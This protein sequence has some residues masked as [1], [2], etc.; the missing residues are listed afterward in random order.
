MS[1]L[2]LYV[3]IDPEL[4]SEL[5]TP[6]VAFGEFTSN[7]PGVVIYNSGGEALQL[8]AFYVD[9]ICGR[10]L[11]LQFVTRELKGIASLVAIALFMDRA[12]AL[13]PKVPALI[14]A[15]ELVSALQEGG[16]A[17]IDR[18]LARLLLFLD[19][20]FFRTPLTKKDM[21]HK[22][23]QVVDWI[24]VWVL[25]GKIPSMGKEPPPPKVL[26]RGTNG[27]VVAET[28]A[29]SQMV[30]G[31]V[32]LY[33]MGFLRG[34]LYAVGA[35]E[36]TYVLAFRKSKYLQF[37]LQEAAGR[38]NGLEAARGNPEGWKVQRHFLTS[39]EWGTMTPRDTLTGVFLRI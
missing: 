38:L 35:D 7:H 8:A 18:D 11:P 22:L 4:P 25:E 23:A 15:V 32:E 6:A 19:H 1:K 28:A 9:L 20:Y 24:R 3:A 2:D 27:F 14:S 31:V 16:L 34:V 5:T 33:R 29:T 21:E 36:R 17:H 12:L 10:P 37:D 13:N 26:D 39:P 30:E